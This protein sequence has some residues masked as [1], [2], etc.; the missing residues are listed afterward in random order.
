MKIGNIKLPTFNWSAQWGGDLT[1]KLTQI[2]QSFTYIVNQHEDGYIFNTTSV[3]AAYSANVSDSVIIAN[4]TFTVTLPAANKCKNKR[5]V[6]KNSG[7]G[8]ITIVGS[9]GNIDGA[10]NIVLS[11]TMESVD[12]V[13]DGTNWWVI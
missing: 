5:F 13:S 8:T 10:A 1:W 6:V 2:I 3:A 7:V 11:V 4:G 9:T 12:L